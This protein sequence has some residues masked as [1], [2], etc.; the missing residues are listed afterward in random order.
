MEFFPGI[1]FS[2]L[3]C[4]FW[5]SLTAKDVI[6]YNTESMESHLKSWSGNCCQICTLPLQL[7]FEG[8]N[9]V[10]ILQHISHGGI[11]S[12]CDTGQR[13]RVPP[14]YLDQT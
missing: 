10:K 12:I 5:P 7:D 9:V 13:Y 11:R 4:I 6:F 8:D 1:Y 3:H 14:A 2:E